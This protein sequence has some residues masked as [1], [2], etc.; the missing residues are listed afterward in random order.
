MITGA[1]AC[2]DLPAG[3]VTKAGGGRDVETYLTTIRRTTTTDA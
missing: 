3:A 2:W 1:E